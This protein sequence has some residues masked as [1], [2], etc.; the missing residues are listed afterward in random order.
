MG[1]NRCVVLVTAASVAVFAG[2]CAVAPEPISESQLTQLGEARLARVS[3]D[4]EPVLGTVDLYEAM[5]RALK[6]N[7]DHRVEMM[8]T[9]V[10]TTELNLSRYD[11]LPNLV[12]G[13]GYAGRDSYNASSSLNLVTDRP[14]FG[15]STSQEKEI[16]TADIAFSWNILDFGLSYVRA[17][18]SGD[19]VLIAA[20][21]RRKVANRIIEDVRIAYWRAVSAER[22]IARLAHLEKRTEVALANTRRVSSEGQTSP[23]AALSYQRELLDIKRTVQS[24]QRDLS[25]AKMQLAALMNLEPGTNF[26]LTLPS[27]YDGRLVLPGSPKDMIWT[28][29]LNR[30]ELRE[31]EYNKRIN[32][33]EADAALLEMLPGLQAYA[34]P[35]FDSNDFL[36]NSNWVGWGAKVSWNL[37]KVINYPAHR[38]VIDAQEEWLDQKAL[39]VTMAVM[40][41]VHVSC[42]RFAHLKREFATTSQYYSVQNRLLEQ[43]RVQAAADRVSE[44]TLIREEMNTLVAEV[45]RDISYAELQNA[46]ANIYASMGIDFYDSELDFSGNV[47]DLS[48]SLRSLWRERGESRPIRLAK[49]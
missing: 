49:S 41:Q 45:Q 36:L 40:T 48:R 18:Q 4:Q 6:Y 24:L 22:L 1:G 30:P 35:S 25:V 17:R 16:K 7:L 34:G 2:G 26:K 33:K 14:N 21:A 19:K 43:M 38:D 29:M 37:M 11:L 12:A 13:S 5:A 46:Y 31:A 27:R 9:V 10:R 20:E 15:A 23:V 44:Q 3:A 32:V 47:G 42:V 39:A 8:Q 28:A